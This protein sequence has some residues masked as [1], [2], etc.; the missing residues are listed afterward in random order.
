MMVA[1]ISFKSSNQIVLIGGEGIFLILILQRRTQAD[2]KW[3]GGES[4]TKT[5]QSISFPCTH[6][7]Q[8][9]N[10][11]VVEGGKDWRQEGKGIT[12]DEMVGWHHQLDGDE[13]QQALGVGDGQ[14]RLACYS[15]W[16]C[17]ESDTTEQL[18]WTE[19]NWVEGGESLKGETQKICPTMEVYEKER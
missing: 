3:L 5:L 2:S 7:S 10:V 6:G 13:F 18:N 16:G 19:L 4:L 15:P 12:E 17:K 14:G 8:Y 9:N 11:L 1:F